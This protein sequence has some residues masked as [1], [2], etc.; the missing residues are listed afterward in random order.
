MTFKLNLRYA[1]IP[2]G[3][4]TCNITTGK[5]VYAIPCGRAMHMVKNMYFSV[6]YGVGSS[7][8][9]SSKFIQEND[10]YQGLHIKAVERPQ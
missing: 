5:S 3:Y 7:D 9:Y 6:Q 1:I 4:R 2:P 8:A 10:T